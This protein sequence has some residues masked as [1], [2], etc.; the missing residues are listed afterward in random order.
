M[1][2]VAENHM[3]IGSS[4]EAVAMI[5]SHGLLPTR[6]HST[7]RDPAKP[8]TVWSVRRPSC[9]A[10]AIGNVICFSWLVQVAPD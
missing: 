6:R 7:A 9:H 10:H 8:P 1:V 4:D 3:V 5:S 2:L